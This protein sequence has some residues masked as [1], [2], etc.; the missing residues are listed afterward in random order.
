MSAYLGQLDSKKPKGFGEYV[1]DIIT[2]FLSTFIYYHDP[3]Y[4]LNNLFFILC[5]CGQNILSRLWISVP[6]FVLLPTHE[7]FALGLHFRSRSCIVR[8][9]Q[10]L[11]LRVTLMI[12]VLYSMIHFLHGSRVQSTKNIFVPY[13]NCPCKVA[14]NAIC[15]LLLI[16]LSC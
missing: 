8:L 5:R 14:H 1:K 2:S 7:I 6:F 12:I 13:L 9:P 4:S 15:I 10:L 11:K 16:L 3:S